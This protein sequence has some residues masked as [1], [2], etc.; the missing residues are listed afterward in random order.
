MAGDGADLAGGPGDEAV[1]LLD[2]H[3]L[4]VH[5]A[6]GHLVLFLLTRVRRLL[7]YPRDDVD[8]LHGV[9]VERLQRSQLPVQV[10]HL[11]ARLHLERMQLRLVGQVSHR[12]VGRVVVGGC[13]PRPE[14]CT[15]M[16]GVTGAR[17]Q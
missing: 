9:R 13:L 2:T 6:L 11:L 7:L 17:V 5:V 3:V 1:P 16:G 4:A 15:A 14:V 10:G 8:Q 12:Q